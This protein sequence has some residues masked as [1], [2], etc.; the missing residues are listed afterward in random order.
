MIP[1]A[2]AC[3]LVALTLISPSACCCTVDAVADWVFQ[4]VFL[5][6]G[7]SQ[8][9]NCCHKRQGVFSSHDDFATCQ[10]EQTA[11]ADEGHCGEDGQHGDSHRCPCR[12]N[13]TSG[14]GPPSP[15]NLNAA[16]TA[17]VIDALQLPYVVPTIADIRSV[18]MIPPVF[19]TSPPYGLCDDSQG[20]LRAYGR[21][22][23]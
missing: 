11:S 21:L 4:G 12:E 10:A 23:I 17:P 2:T 20:I 13:G 1:K 6:T 5:E 8:P 18:G 16:A 14:S 15:L 7:I 22:R 19:L 3:L 9:A